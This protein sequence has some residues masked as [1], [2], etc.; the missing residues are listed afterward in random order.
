MCPPEESLSIIIKRIKEGCWNG[1]NKAK[2]N[3]THNH[4]KFLI[5]YFLKKCISSIIFTSD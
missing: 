2:Q 3:K 1:K 4:G 5:K